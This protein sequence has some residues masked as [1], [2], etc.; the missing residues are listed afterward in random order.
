M[1]ASGPDSCRPRLRRQ[2]RFAVGLAWI[3]L[4]V[5]FGSASAAAPGTPPGE[6]H[7]TEATAN[8][9]GGFPV[10]MAGLAPAVEPDTVTVVA[11]GDIACDPE[12]RNFS[13][14]VGH[15]HECKQ[16]LTAELA[17]TFDPGAVLA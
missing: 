14:G 6:A 2:L 11:V 13:G 8:P 7:A 5:C 3:L 4:V 16:A 12:H 9:A 15:D 10:T 17:A 1:H